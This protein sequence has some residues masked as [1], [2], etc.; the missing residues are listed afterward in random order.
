[1][2]IA[3]WMVQFIGRLIG[4]ASVHI[5]VVIGFVVLSAKYPSESPIVTL[6]PSPVT[7][8]DATYQ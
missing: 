6:L 5:V 4:Y 8:I 7:Y 2:V 1:M 3:K